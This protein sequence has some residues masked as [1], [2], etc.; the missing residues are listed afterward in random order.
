MSGIKYVLVSLV[1]LALLAVSF[2]SFVASFYAVMPILSLVSTLINC[3]LLYF[4]SRRLSGRKRKLVLVILC[5]LLSA[6]LLLAAQ[7]QYPRWIYGAAGD[8]I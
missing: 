7:P 8:E 2:G 1:I 5:A 6:G 4:W 3:A